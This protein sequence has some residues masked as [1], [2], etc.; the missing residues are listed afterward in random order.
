ME[1]QKWCG[2]VARVEDKGRSISGLAEDEFELWTWTDQVMREGR[3]GPI[4]FITYVRVSI[5]IVQNL[6]K[7][8]LNAS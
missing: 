8:K 1:T 4:S 5:I 7:R 6:Y 2:R 3:A